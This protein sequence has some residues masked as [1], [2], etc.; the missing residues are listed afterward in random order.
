M[1][2]ARS[3]SGGV[4]TLTPRPS[5]GTGLVGRSAERRLLAAMIAGLPDRGGAV[6]VRGEAGIGK[7]ALLAD[8]VLSALSTLRRVWVS[9]TESE[10][11]LPFAAIADLLRPLLGHVDQLCE[12]QRSALRVALALEN[13][14]TPSP[15]AVCA[16]VL[17]VL[18]AAGACEPLLVVVDDFQWID[19]YL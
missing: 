11:V 13:G 10:I 12:A 6:F 7:T 19:P 3:F 8:A 16:A 15:L 17:G 4:T 1:V 18:A 14:P 5:T 2:V 9:G